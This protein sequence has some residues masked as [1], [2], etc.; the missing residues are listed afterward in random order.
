MESNVRYVER[1]LRELSRSE[2]VRQ[3]V[4]LGLDGVYDERGQ[5]DLAATDF[6]IS[7]RYVHQIA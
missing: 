3:A 2:T 5:L 4:L 7:N 6:L 1:L